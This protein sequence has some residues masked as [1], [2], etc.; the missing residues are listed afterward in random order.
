MGYVVVDGKLKIDT[1]HTRTTTSAEYKNRKMMMLNPLQQ[2]IVSTK[3]FPFLKRNSG[4]VK[5]KSG[6][7]NS[8]VVFVELCHFPCFGLVIVGLP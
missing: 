8:N 4:A 5:S 1:D 7:V 3:E 2:L 6:V